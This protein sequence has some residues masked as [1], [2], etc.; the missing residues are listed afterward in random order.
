[1]GSLIPLSKLLKAEFISTNWYGA[2]ES[3]NECYIKMGI[4][5]PITQIMVFLCCINT[6][7]IILLGIK[8]IEYLPYVSHRHVSYVSNE[9]T[10]KYVNLWHMEN[11]GTEI[12]DHVKSCL[13]V[14]MLCI[15]VKLE[16]HVR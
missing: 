1:M 12:F 13:F 5:F 2:L 4:S 16:R 14:L 11:N 10:G 15:L 8:K 6:R 9:E 7:P 3:L